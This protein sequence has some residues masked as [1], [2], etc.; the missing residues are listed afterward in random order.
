[1][2]RLF[3][4]PQALRNIV[5]QYQNVVSGTG[6]RFDK[7][8]GLGKDIYRRP[9]VLQQCQAN[10]DRLAGHFLERFEAG[11]AISGGALAWDMAVGRGA[12]AR[13]IPYVAVIPFVGQESRW[14]AA[15]Q[16]MYRELLDDAL[17]V[18]VVSDGAF[19]GAKMHRRNEAMVDHADRVLALW[20]GTAG[21]TG[22]CVNYA[23]RQR[24][25][26][27]NVW[28]PYRERLWIDG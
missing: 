17:A 21:G 28:R 7:L 18:V 24:V 27:S 14:A 16:R 6:H 5:D 9:A 20:D 3:E 10:L 1:M 15:Q 23:L 25:R 13:G 11:L 19:S 12:K 8:T 22:H 2:I 4:D 26:V